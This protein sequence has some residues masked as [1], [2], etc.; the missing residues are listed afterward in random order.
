MN[1]DQTNAFLRTLL[2]F[3]GTAIG[4]YLISHGYLNADQLSTAAG[5]LTALAGAAATLTPI[6]LSLYKAYSANSAKAKL[7]SVAAMPEVTSV[8]MVPAAQVL[9]DSVPSSK[10]AVSVAKVGAFLL[11]CVLGSILLGAPRAE[12]AT[13]PI[14]L[15]LPAFP[16]L[17]K[18]ALFGGKTVTLDQIVASVN[19]HMIQDLKAGERVF[20]ALGDAPALGCYTE[21]DTEFS[22]ILAA[23]A[24]QPAVD[25]IPAVPA[26]ATTPA[27]PAIAAV[28]AS[29]ALSS[30]HLFLDIAIARTLANA[31]A[32]NS[33]FNNACA[34][35]A[36]QTGQSVTAFITG[37][38]TGVLKVGPLFGMP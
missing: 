32:T 19:A 35:V 28:P 18:L 9:A 12:A 2:T 13:V 34:A 10:V 29:P 11:A 30:P 17:S 25:A 5:A 27:I 15:T 22:A 37:A 8:N 21:I 4:T 3:C 6:A 1:N 38:I 24:P 23:V 20:S 26:T 7:A 33:K 16:N 36:I 14:G 31:A